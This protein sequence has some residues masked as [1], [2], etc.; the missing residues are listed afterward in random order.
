MNS[1]LL[2]FWRF[3]LHFAV[4]LALHAY[5]ICAVEMSHDGLPPHTSSQPYLRCRHVGRLELTLVATSKPWKSANMSDQSSIYCFVDCLNSRKQQRL[6][7][8][9][10]WNLKVCHVCGRTHTQ[11]KIFFHHLAKLLSASTK[12]TFFMEEYVKPEQAAEESFLPSRGCVWLLRAGALGLRLERRPLRPS[13]PHC[14]PPVRAGNYENP[15]LSV[16]SL[17]CSLL[18]KRKVG[19]TWKKKCFMEFCCLAY[20]TYKG[21]FGTEKRTNKPQLDF[22]DLCV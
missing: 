8:Q 18:Q 12:V 3:L 22:V 2:T 6:F 17:L 16:P 9:C 4:P 15:L 19:H 10:R 5:G 13:H 7:Y 21:A 20:S 14:W 11:V 1:N